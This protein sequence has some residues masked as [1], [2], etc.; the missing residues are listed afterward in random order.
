MHDEHDMKSTNTI[1]RAVR[2]FSRVT[3][4]EAPR[5]DPTSYWNARTDPNNDE[6]RNSARVA[7]EVNYIATN[8][9]TSGRVLELGPGVGRTFAAYPSTTRVATIDISRLYASRLAETADRLGV[10]LEQT[11][12]EDL[13]SRFPFDDYE[14]DCGVAFQVF[15]HQP[16]EVFSHQFAEMCRVCRR[17]L[18]CAGLHANTGNAQKA[19]ATHVFAHDYLVESAKCG[20]IVQNLLVRDAVLYFVA[21]EDEKGLWSCSDSPAAGRRNS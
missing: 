9:P 16:K 6:G 17:V 21:C 4:S 5:Y 14:F 8:L 3:G 13:T 20:R 7:F 18:V 2:A 19:M 12:I 10:Q 11:F 1:L 15:I